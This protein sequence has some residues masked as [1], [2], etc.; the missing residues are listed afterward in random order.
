MIPDT[1]RKKDILVINLISQTLDHLTNFLSK[2][3]KNN[4]EKEEL[5]K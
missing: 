2:I 4:L 5:L 3:K 1:I